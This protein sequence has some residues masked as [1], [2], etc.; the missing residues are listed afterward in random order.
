MPV[1]KRTKTPQEKE[2]ASNIIAKPNPGPTHRSVN[3]F[4]GISQ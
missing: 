4:R 2:P 3:I 1:R